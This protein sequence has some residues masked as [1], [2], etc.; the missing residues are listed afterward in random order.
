MENVIEFLKGQDR[1]TVTF[2]TEKWKNRIRK[3]AEEHPDEVDIVFEDETYVTGHVPVNWVK[4][5]PPRV[6]TD[7]QKAEMAERLK[8]LREGMI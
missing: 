8:K 1:A 5:N 7:E 4:V 6:Y 2:S 3:L